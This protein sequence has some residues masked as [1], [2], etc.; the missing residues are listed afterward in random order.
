M[1]RGGGV[2]VYSRKGMRA[3]NIAIRGDESLA[4]KVNDWILSF[5]YVPPQGNKYATQHWEQRIEETLFSL[6][7][8]NNKVV[9]MG[10]PW[11]CENK[12]INKCA[13]EEDLSFVETGMR[14]SK[15]KVTNPYGKKLIELCET[16]NFCIMNVR[17]SMDREGE[18][19][20]CHHTQRLICD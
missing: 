8:L 16:T 5:V 9:L 10:D 11:Y 6:C 7:T 15:D 18:F 3:K 2:S 4:S 19:T 17:N 14:N 1:V 13:Y 20:F 12:N